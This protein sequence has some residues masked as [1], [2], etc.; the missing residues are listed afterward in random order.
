MSWSWCC[1]VISTMR[2]QDDPSLLVASSVLD[3]ADCRFVMI[4]RA[5]VGL[6]LYGAWA[7]VFHVW[8]LPT[9]G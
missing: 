7:V 2:A 1:P 8:Y 3:T 4:P 9:S 5:G 6:L